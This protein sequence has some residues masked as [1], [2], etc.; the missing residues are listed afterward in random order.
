M[1]EWINFKSGQDEAMPYQF[2]VKPLY[3]SNL[4]CRLKPYPDIRTDSYQ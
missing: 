2:K 3:H 1:L 4:R